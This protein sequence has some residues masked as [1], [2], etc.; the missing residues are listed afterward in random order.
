MAVVPSKLFHGVALRLYP[1]AGRTYVR[2]V[3]EPS[4]R[5]GGWLTRCYGR[6]LVELYQVKVFSC[7]VDRSLSRRHRDERGVLR[8]RHFSEFLER[9]H[10]R[11]QGSELDARADTVPCRIVA[12][13]QH[14][15]ASP[16]THIRSGIGI[17]EEV[18]H[19]LTER[20]AEIAPNLLHVA[21]AGGYVVVIE[22]GR[23]FTARCLEDLRRIGRDAC[24]RGGELPMYPCRSSVTVADERRLAVVGG[25]Q[26]E[27]PRRR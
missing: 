23:R 24:P 1:L 25:E 14:R 19:E 4:L 10:E 27:Y 16:R 7:V 2:H 15:R 17:G 21:S 12:P 11:L 20:Y 6:E 9:P 22:G 13:T 18:A 26:V 5:L 8:L 3:E